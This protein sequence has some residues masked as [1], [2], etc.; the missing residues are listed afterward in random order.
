MRIFF[1]LLLLFFFSFSCAT[2]NVSQKPQKVE[3]VYLEPVTNKTPEEG[4]DVIF[5]K[6][7][8]DVFYSDS[9]FKVERTPKPGVTVLVKPS[10]DSISIYAV[11]FDK[12]DR[13][14]EYKMT[15]STTIKLIRYGFKNPL[16][17]FSISRYDFYDAT[18]A[19]QEVERK[20]KECIERIAYQ[21]FRELGEKI[22]I[23][24]EKIENQK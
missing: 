17:T 10:V 9:R 16:Y 1:F 3:H 18:G 19:P 8:N 6:V 21:I 7:A 11:G 4:A 23:S 12:Y 22:A 5:T 2:T 20:R 15:I 14:T 24:G 13:V